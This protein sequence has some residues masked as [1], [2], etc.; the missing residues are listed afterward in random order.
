MFAPV[1]DAGNT[2]MPA[3]SLHLLQAAGLLIGLPK[4][5]GRIGN[6]NG[7]F[8]RPHVSLPAAL[9]L[10]PPALMSACQRARPAASAQKGRVYS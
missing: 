4:Y 2:I 8:P 1:Q 5:A 3:H 9:P 10:A 6:S 7:L